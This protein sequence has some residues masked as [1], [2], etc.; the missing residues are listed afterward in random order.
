MAQTKAVRI[1]NLHKKVRLK[2]LLDMFSLF[3]RITGFGMD[4]DAFVLGLE[5]SPE[6]ALAMNNLPLAYRRMR[7]ELVDWNGEYDSLGA[8]DTVVFTAGSLDT[9]DI[10]DE[11]SMFGSVVEVVRRWEMIYVVCETEADASRVVVNMYGRYHNKQRIRC[12][13]LNRRHG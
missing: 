1:S 12:H 4:E 10:R 13:V 7:V 5:P 2:D 3:G 6:R 8:G 11:C 9:D